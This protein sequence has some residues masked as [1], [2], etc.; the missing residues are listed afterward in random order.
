VIEI[1]SRHE[2]EEVRGGCGELHG[3]LNV[4]SVVLLILFVSIREAVCVVPIVNLKGYNGTYNLSMCRV[5]VRFVPPRLSG[6]FDTIS[7]EDSAFVA[8]KVTGNNRRY[9]GLRVKVPIFLP[10]LNQIYFF[11]DRFS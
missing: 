3:Q 4:S 9:L 6:L 11:L 5:G 7:I 2:S 10:I 8:I 1:I